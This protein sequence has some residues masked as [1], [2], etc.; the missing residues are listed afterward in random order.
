MPAPAAAFGIFKPTLDPTAHA[1][2]DGG[3]LCWLQISHD[4]PHFLI[5]LIPTSQQD[6]LQA[7]DLSR[8]TVHFPTPGTAHAGRC[9]GETAKLAFPLRAEMALLVNAHERMPAKFHDLG[10]EPRS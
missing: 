4:H 2:P 5:A 10:V 9:C 8:K 7:T 3:G 1:V 6:T